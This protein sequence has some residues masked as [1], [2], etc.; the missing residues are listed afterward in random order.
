MNNNGLAAKARAW[1]EDDL[2]GLADLIQRADSVE[3]RPGAPPFHPW[4]QPQPPSALSILLDSEAS[5]RRR[6]REAILA[7][8]ASH[9]VYR[10]VTASV[11]RIGQSS[12][13]EFDPLRRA[14]IIAKAALRARLSRH[15]R[16]SRRPNSAV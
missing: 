12:A 10:D 4:L 14:H 9:A 11:P 5:A 3:E 8:V 7:Q 1:S 15:H 6:E 2:K 13:S 16:H